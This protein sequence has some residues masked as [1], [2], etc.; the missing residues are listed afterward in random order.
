MVQKWE[1]KSIVIY[2]KGVTPELV[3]LGKQGWEG[4]G[5]DS[6]GQLHLKRPL[7]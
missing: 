3:E 5:F 4:Y 7:P 1:Y 2:G 6:F